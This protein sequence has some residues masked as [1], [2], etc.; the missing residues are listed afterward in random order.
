MSIEAVLPF[1]RNLDIATLPG[2]D[3]K[4]LLDRRR[5]ALSEFKENG[6]P[7]RKWEDWKYTSLRSLEDTDYRQTTDC[8]GRQSIESIPSLNADSFSPRLVFVEGVYRPDLSR[9]KGLPS[10]VTLSSMRQTLSDSPNFLKKT[11]NSL[12][13]R[14]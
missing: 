2:G 1:F 7:T 11:M 6:L 4:W 9:T 10:D 12:F 5:A 3:L 13:G 14:V 8:D